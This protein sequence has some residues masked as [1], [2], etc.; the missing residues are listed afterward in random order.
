MLMYTNGNGFDVMLTSYDSSWNSVSTIATV[1][2]DVPE[3]GTF[4]AIAMGLI[5]AAGFRGRFGKK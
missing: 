2:A 5:G 3:P 1:T 4:I